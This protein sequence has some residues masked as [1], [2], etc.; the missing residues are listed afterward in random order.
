MADWLKTDRQKLLAA[1]LE[2][3]NLHDDLGLDS[4]WTDETKTQSGLKQSFLIA[5]WL[6]TRIK[7]G[8]DVWRLLAAH[9]NNIVRE[10]AAIIVGLTD[11]IP[12]ARK[13]AWMKTFADDEHPGLREIAWLALRADVIRDPLSAICC[14]VP[15][16]GSRNERLRRLAVEVTRPSGVGCSPIPILQ[17]QPELGL[18]ILEPLSADDSEYVQIAVGNWI[19]DASK[20]K[21]DWV[22]AITER[23]LSESASDNTQAILKQVLGAIE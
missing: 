17:D 18:P 4:L 22:Q 15:W 1:I 10:W 14:L 13:L 2:Q 16:T 19:V 3:L 7:I 12:F 8:D 21:P 6:S 20:S 11:S 23:W 9:S 5:N